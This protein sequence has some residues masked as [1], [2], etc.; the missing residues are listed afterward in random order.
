LC[1]EYEGL[2]REAYR[3][4][5]ADI[6]GYSDFKDAWIKAW[7]PVAL[8]WWRERKESEVGQDRA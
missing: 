1:R 5:P 4:F 7:E 8:S 2:K 3:R 6:E